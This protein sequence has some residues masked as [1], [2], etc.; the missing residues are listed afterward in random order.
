MKKVLVAA[1]LALVANYAS[2]AISGS[3][4]D[5]TA[6]YGNGAKCAYCHIPHNSL[7]TSGFAPLWARN[8]N[9]GQTYTVYSSVFGGQKAGQP[10]TPSRLCLSCHDGTQ[11]VASVYTSNQ[12]LTTYGGIGTK[13]S[14]LA[15][16]GT[17]LS[18]DHPVGITYSNT[19]NNNNAGLNATVPA[20]FKIYPATVG[21]GTVECT[22][23]HNAH[24]PKNVSSFSGRQFMV[25]TGLTVDF[26]SA[27]HSAK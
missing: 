14:G 3:S 15:L 1:A 4:H 9:A 12:T 23:C 26:C 8:M 21:V 10:G 24:T 20:P 17:N 11:A 18:G 19:L 22:S 6:S 25:S 5:L 16:S 13:I 7:D 2:A 27:C